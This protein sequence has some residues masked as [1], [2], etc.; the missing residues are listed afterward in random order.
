[1]VATDIRS[2]VPQITA[3]TVVVRQTL[4]S[5]REEQQL[6]VS[7]LH[8]PRSHE[9]TIA[10]EEEEMPCQANLGAITVYESSLL[11][12]VGEQGRGRM[13]RD[14]ENCMVCLE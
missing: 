7:E 13:L 10:C 11:D 4:Q 6:Q 12:D 5:G 1:M 14:L 2:L 8:W 9:Q 3:A